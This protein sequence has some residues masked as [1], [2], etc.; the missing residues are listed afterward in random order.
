MP[1]RRATNSVLLMRTDTGNK[2][3][4]RFLQENR[5]I[6]RTRWSI[7]TISGKMRLATTVFSWWL[8][9]CRKQRKAPHEAGLDVAKIF[10]LNQREFDFKCFNFFGIVLAVCIFCSEIILKGFQYVNCLGVFF[11]GFFGFAFFK[12]YFS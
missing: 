11:L 2:L 4:C 9:I 6:K 5:K 10:L 12:V 3:V 7:C 1:E 8:L